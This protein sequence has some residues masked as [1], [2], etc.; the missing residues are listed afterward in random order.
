MDS[1]LENEKWTK[2]LL[3]FESLLWKSVMFSPPGFSVFTTQVK[4]FPDIVYP[5]WIGRFLIRSLI[6]WSTKISVIMIAIW[7]C[8]SFFNIKILQNV[9]ADSRKL[10][11]NVFVLKR[12]FIS[13]LWFNI[14]Q[15][16]SFN[17]YWVSTTC[18]ALWQFLRIR[19]KQYSKAMLATKYQKIFQKNKF[20]KQ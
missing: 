9:T 4:L 20:K 11:I 3:P 15:L 2:I 10:Q 14:S 19:N 6:L 12:S 18:I 13:S 16:H 7:F 1:P 8:I 17:K 5:N